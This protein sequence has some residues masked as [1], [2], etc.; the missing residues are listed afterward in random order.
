MLNQ[1]LRNHWSFKQAMC[2]Y[3]P[4]A[5][6]ANG[7]GSNSLP[8]GSVEAPTG[9][10]G[11]TAPESTPAA[12]TAAAAAS[13]KGSRSSGA[14]DCARA[15]ETE[16][17]AS[18][19]GNGNGGV[20]GNSTDDVSQADNVG[21]ASL[22]VAAGGADDSVKVKGTPHAASGRK[23]VSEDRQRGS[24]DSTRAADAAEEA[25]VAPFSHQIAIA[26]DGTSPARP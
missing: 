23:R 7:G 1:A 4:G 18:A 12:A 21:A 19:G 25:A 10:V 24:E 2:R 3:T 13:S 17:A 15:G 26:D 9:N 14:K 11:T 6:G 22:E 20:S 8:A 5:A 16:S